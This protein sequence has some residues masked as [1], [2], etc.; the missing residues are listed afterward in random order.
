MNLFRTSITI[1]TLIFTTL[2]VFIAC[3]DKAKEPVPEPEK[4]IIKAADL[5]FLPEIE[6]AG[7]IFYNKDNQPEDMLST[8]QKAG[9]NTVRIRLWKNPLN[10]HSSFSEVKL[11]AEKVRAKG[12]KVWLTVH[13]S[14]TWADPGNQ[15]VPDAW[16]DLGYYILKDSVY[17]YTAEIVSKIKPDYIQIGNEINNGFMW[18]Q[19]SSAYQTNFRELLKAGSK[20]VRDQDP[21]CKIILH[22]AG[23]ENSSAFFSNLQDIDFD[24]IGLSYYPLWHGKSLSLLESTMNSL[25]RQF[26][27]QVMIAETSYP[28]TLGWNDWTNNIMGLEEQLLEGYPASPSGQKAYLNEIKRIS[29]ADEHSIGFAYWGGEWIAFK[30]PQATNGSSYENQAFYDFNLKVLPV[31]EVFGD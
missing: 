3:S 27:K 19:G 8:L 9:L 13:Y 17:H 10:E 18:P 7:I 2:L 23:I 5:S 4:F 24:I 11:F 25:G 28:F 21:N 31:I 14:D 15:L 16:K 6:Q 20:A 29:T 12:L 26:S 22:Y 1:I 30:G